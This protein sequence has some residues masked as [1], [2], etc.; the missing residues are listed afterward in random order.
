MLSLP[1]PQKRRK[2]KIEDI[3]NLTKLF[4]EET[5]QAVLPADADS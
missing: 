2:K 4:L 3:Y 5:G 1:P